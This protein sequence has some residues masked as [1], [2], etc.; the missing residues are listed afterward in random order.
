MPPWPCPA[1]L[2]SPSRSPSC[3]RSSRR[4]GWF[5]Y[6]RNI[7]LVDVATVRSGRLAQTVVVSGRVLAP[8]KVDV[9]ATITGRVRA[10]RGRRRCQG[11]RQRAPDRA[12]A[13]RARGSARAGARDERAAQTRIAQWR[14]VA[15]PNARELVTQAEAN[16]RVAERDLARQEDLVGRRVRRRSARRRSPARGRGRPEPGRDAPGLPRPRTGRRARNASC[17]RTSSRRPARHASAAE[18]KLDQTRI[19]A[20]QTASSSI[21]RSSPATSCSPRSG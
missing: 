8:A 20:P 7:P 5:L 12:R 18:A 4:L 14:A 13:L 21:A 16:L 19:L 17:S 3:W 1:F 10:R 11:R 15:A 6:A 9:G 2:A